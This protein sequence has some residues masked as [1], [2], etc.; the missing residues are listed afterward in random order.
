MRKYQYIQTID[1]PST[2]FNYLL[3]IG[4]L[5]RYHNKQQFDIPDIVIT[6]VYC[7][8]KLDEMMRGEV[9]EAKVSVLTSYEPKFHEPSLPVYPKI[10]SP[11]STLSTNSRPLLLMVRFKISL[12]LAS[13]VNFI[14]IFLC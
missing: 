3:V 8:D 9:I 5:R 13:Y 12:S 14:I 4:I 6:R 11:T 10:S 7:T 1:I 2:K